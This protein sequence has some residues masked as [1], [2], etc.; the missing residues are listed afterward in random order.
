[1]IPGNAAGLC[2]GCRYARIIRNERNSVF[3]LCRRAE[4][5]PSLRKYPPLPVLNCHAYE[6]ASPSV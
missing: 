4:T 6:K 2:A 3:V 5:D 1:M